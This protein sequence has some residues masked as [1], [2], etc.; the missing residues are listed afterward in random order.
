MAVVFVGIELRPRAT[1]ERISQWQRGTGAF[2]SGATDSRARL[3]SC[4]RGGGGLIRDLKQRG[5]PED[6]LVVY[7]LTDIHGN[8]VKSLLV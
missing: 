8:V 1:G 5:L 4:Q 7:R 3:G 6:T 2:T